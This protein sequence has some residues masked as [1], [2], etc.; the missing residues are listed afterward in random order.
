MQSEISAIFAQ[1][2]DFLPSDAVQ[3]LSKAFLQRYA[4][5][6]SSATRE[7]VPSNRFG[8]LELFLFEEIKRV[9][10]QNPRLDLRYPDE[11]IQNL[12][13]LLT[14]KLERALAPH[15]SRSASK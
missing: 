8:E 2:L 12:V 9:V 1:Y 6:Y 5:L 4:S 3:N 10:R 15:W 7:Q 11:A 13:L 14:D